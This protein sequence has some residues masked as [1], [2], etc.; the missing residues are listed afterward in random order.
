MGH[1]HHIYSSNGSGVILKE[2]LKDHNS[3]RHLMT[4][5]KQHILFMSDQLYIQ[6]ESSCNGTHN[7]LDMKQEK[8]PNMEEK[9]GHEIVL[10]CKELCGICGC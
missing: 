6:S 10:L 1:L 7:L 8:S 2:G 9:N 5:M 4:T 3:E